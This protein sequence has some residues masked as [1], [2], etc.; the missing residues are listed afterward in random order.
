M[1]QPDDRADAGRGHQQPDAM[2]FARG[3]NAFLQLLPLFE[4]RAARRASAIGDSVPGRVIGGAALILALWR[5]S[6]ASL[7]LVSP[8]SRRHSASP[9]EFFGFGEMLLQYR[10]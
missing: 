5:R 2:I 8:C 7:G 9:G 1:G 6:P 4:K 10:C 3:S